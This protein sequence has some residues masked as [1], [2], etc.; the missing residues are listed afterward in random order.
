[1]SHSGAERE[2]HRV[3]TIQAGST[4]CVP[5]CV[6]SRPL[7]RPPPDAGPRPA[8]RHRRP[9]V[10]VRQGQ[11]LPGRSRRLQRH[12]HRQ[13]RDRGAGRGERDADRRRPRGEGRR[14]ERRGVLPG[15]PERPALP[16][17]P[18]RL[19]RAPQA[20][21]RQ[22]GAGCPGRQ[23]EPGRGQGRRPRGRSGRPDRQA[24]RAG[25]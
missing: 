22:G 7:A 3:R 9:R 20:D 19:L 18:A 21:V 8:A 23:E 24:H 10:R 11:G 12:G 17:D 13:G 14:Q 6:P 5:T 1:M 25:Q 2:G 4:P 15:L 16:D